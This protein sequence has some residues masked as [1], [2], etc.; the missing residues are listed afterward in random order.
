MSTLVSGV[1]VLMAVS[2]IALGTSALFQSDFSLEH[3]VSKALPSGITVALFGMTV[4]RGR[5]SAL[6]PNQII[7]WAG[8]ACAKLRE[9]LSLKLS[10][11]AEA[12][13]IAES[14][15]SRMERGLSPMKLFNVEAIASTLK[16]KPIDIIRKAHELYCDSLNETYRNSQ[17]ALRE[18]ARLR[19]RD[20][21]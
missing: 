10:E 14:V 11:V 9:G 13:G 3:F 4:P 12:C 1:K 21:I 17:Y 15:L 2:L 8:Q 18:I 16:V 19:P 6:D 20:D 7:P 5:V